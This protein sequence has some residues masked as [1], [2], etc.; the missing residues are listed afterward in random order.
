M[1]LEAKSANYSKT[2]KPYPS[3]DIITLDFSNYQSL[4]KVIAEE[5]DKFALPFEHVALSLIAG[6]VARVKQAK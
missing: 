6:A 3:P 5:A 1:P 4:K 2:E